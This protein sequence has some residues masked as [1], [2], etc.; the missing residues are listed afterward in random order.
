[1]DVDRVDITVP[2]APATTQ[3]SPSASPRRRPSA[4]TCVANASRVQCAVA[5][6]TTICRAAIAGGLAGGAVLLL[7]AA[8]VVL[9][10]RRSWRRSGT[11]GTISSHSEVGVSP[12]PPFP[13]ISP[14][15]IQPAVR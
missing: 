11:L 15:S 9:Y 5:S 6:P 2:D 10:H 13:T 4:S 3:P 1:M 14:Y 7:I 8:L 12:V